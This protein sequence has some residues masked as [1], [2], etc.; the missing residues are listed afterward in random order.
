MNNLL[1]LL[2]I[3]GL[4]TCAVVIVALGF[5]RH[6]A[7]LMA[8]VTLVL[9]VLAVLVYLLPT[10]LA[11]YRGCKATI[12]IGL[13]NVFLGWTILGWAA[14]MGWAASGQIREPVHPIGAPPVHHVSGH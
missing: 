11:M 5:V 8:P 3:A 4:A 14:A 7:D 1:P 2:V 12:W 6:D 10:G 13:V 9:F